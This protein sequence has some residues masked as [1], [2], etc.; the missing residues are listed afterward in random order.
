MASK[1]AAGTRRGELLA[2]FVLAVVIWPFIAVGVVGGFGFLVWMY[3]LAV[4]PP[5]AG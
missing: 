5:G 1:P 2:F 4:G 3:H